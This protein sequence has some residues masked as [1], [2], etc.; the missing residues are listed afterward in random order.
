MQHMKKYQSALP[1]WA[2]FSM[3]TVYGLIMVT[4]FFMIAR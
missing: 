3:G 2:W 4:V 1:S